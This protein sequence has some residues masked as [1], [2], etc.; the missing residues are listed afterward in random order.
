MKEL[1]IIRAK[2]GFI[3]SDIPAHQGYSSQW[4]Y[5][6]LDEALAGLKKLMEKADEQQD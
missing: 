2:H 5:S 6:T 1:M 4:A 3:V